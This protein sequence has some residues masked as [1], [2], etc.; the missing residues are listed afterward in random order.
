MAQPDAPSVSISPAT[1]L[2][3]VPAVTDDGET[4]EFH[5]FLNPL[6]QMGSQI[7]I[8]SENVNGSYVV[9]SLSHNA[10][11]WSGSFITAV[12]VRAL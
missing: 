1:G 8:T 7:T 3:G 12:D 10:D 4:V 6:I 2:V 5:S 11:N 9:S